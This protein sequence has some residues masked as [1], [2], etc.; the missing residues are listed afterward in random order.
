MGS[1]GKTVQAPKPKAA[2]RIAAARMDV[3]VVE[4]VMANLYYMFW[5]MYLSIPSTAEIALE[6]IS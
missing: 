2:K 4:L 3:L 5:L 6:L 1:T